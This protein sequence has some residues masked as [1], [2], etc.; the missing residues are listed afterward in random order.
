[1]PVVKSSKVSFSL[2][3]T[4][5]IVISGSANAALDIAQS[6]LFINAAVPPLNMLVMGRD[7]TLYYEAYNDASDLD[8]DGLLDIRF[9]P[10]KIDYYGYFDSAKCYQYAEGNTRFE[11]VGATSNSRFDGSCNGNWSGNFLN[12]V[13]MSRIDALRKVLYGGKRVTDTRTDDGAGVTVLERSAIPQDGHSWGKEYTSLAVDGYDISDYTPLSVPQAGTRHLFANVTIGASP[14]TSGNAPLLRVLRNSRFRIW[15]WVSIEAPVA[16][17]RC[18]HGGSGPTCVYDAGQDTSHPSSSLEFSD[19][20]DRMQGNVLVDGV[21]RT[22]INKTAS[23]AGALADSGTTAGQADNYVSVLKGIIKVPTSGLYKFAV[24]GDDAVEVLI[25]GQ[26]IVG[27]YGGHG[28]GSFADH[29]G[30]ITLTAGNHNIEF[31]HEEV[32]GGDSYSLAW[33]NGAAWDVVPASWFENLRLWAYGRTVPASTRDNPDYVVRVQVCAAELEEDNCQSYTRIDGDNSYLTY[34]PV[35]LLQEFGTATDNT[36]PAR[37]KFG[38]LTGSYR[39]NLKG[40]VLRRNVGDISDELDVETGVFNNTVVGVIETID[41]LGFMGYNGSQHGSNG[42]SGGCGLITGR[43]IDNNQCNMW[44]NPVAEMI[45]ETLRYFAGARSATSAFSE[46]VSTSAYETGLG[47]PLAA[48]DDPYS[49]QGAYSCAAP[50]QTIISDINPSYDTDDLPGTAFGDGVTVSPSRLSS[51]NVAK[52]GQTIWNGEFG[53]GVSRQHFIGQSAAASDGAPTAKSVTSFGNIRGLAPAEPTKMGGYY[54]ASLAYYGLRND[55][56]AATGEQ[57]LSSYVVAL[58]SPLPQFRIPVGDRFITLVPFGKS[59]GSGSTPYGSYYPTNTIVDFY[60]ENIAEDGRSGTFRINFEDVEQG[61]DHD[62]DA[63]VRYEYEVIGDSQLRLRLTSEYAAGSVVQH[64]G[65]VISGSTADG[66]Y[67]EVRD[68]DTSVANDVSVA[69]TLDTPPSRARP[70]DARGADELPLQTTRT[71][72]VNTSSGASTASLLKGPLWYA[73]KWGGFKDRNG[74]GIPDLREEWTGADA[75]ELDP[76]PDNYYLVTNALGLRDQLSSAFN[77]ILIQT[78]SAAA[79]A[80]NSTRLDT[81][82]Q[83]FQAR[84]NSEFWSGELRALSLNANGSIGTTAWEASELIPPEDGRLIATWDH[85]AEV[86]VEFEWS[87]LS[88]TYQAAMGSETVLNYVRGDTGNER[89]NGGTYR[90]RPAGLLG[91]IVNSDPVFVGNQDFGF[92]RLPVGS[93]ERPLLGSNPYRDFKASVSRKAMVYAGAND[94]MLH[95]FCAGSCGSASPGQEILAYVPGA[96]AYAPGQGSTEPARLIDLANP[97]YQH[98]YYVD[99]SARVVD[100]YLGSGDSARWA[101]VLVGSLGAG[102]RS[103]FALDVTNPDEFGAEKVLWEFPRASTAVAD[104]LEVGVGITQPTISRLAAG[105]KWVAIFG[106]GYNSQSGQ[107]AL[108]IVDLNTGDLI[109]RI[110]V[111]A[112]GE[113]GLSAVYPADT[114]GDGITDY[115][116]A[117]DMKGNVWRFDLN[118]TTQTSWT[119]GLSGKPVFTT[120]ANQPITTRIVAGSHPSGGVM[121]Y[122]G[123][124]RYLGDTDRVV[125]DNPPV[126][127][128]YGLWD[129]SAAVNSLNM[130]NKTRLVSLNDLQQ[131]SIIY[132]SSSATTVSGSAASF[133]V[134]VMSNTEFEYGTSSSRKKGW[135]LDLVYPSG[136]AGDG[137]RVTSAATLRAGKIIFATNTPS[138]DACAYGG[139]SWLMEVDALSGKQLDGSVFDVNNDGK[140]DDADFALWGSNRGGVGGR[141]FD[142]LIRN[143]GIISGGEIEYKYTSGSSG[144]I[145][146]TKE[147]AGSAATGRQS[148]RQLQ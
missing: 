127:S 43:A 126:Q 33:W 41:R 72:T 19:L 28:T 78:S 60:V 94:G 128:F 76:D 102:G 134:R 136:A 142:E 69:Y 140:I 70:S 16:G 18:E 125:V 47:L 77:N 112:A 12:Y 59:V 36:S 146:V 55:L 37:M 14:A 84:F 108:F 32:G 29:A 96:L 71:F 105:N 74:N 54:S 5:L 98:R 145:G 80:T 100:A 44:G 114:N 38:L 130:S 56:S 42:N 123:T 104:R 6:P 11:P 135:Y 40:G 20:I 147:D 139:S 1:M 129:Y 10:S 34:K 113:N 13:T 143:P 24:N 117:G 8:G 51:L 103:I 49:R 22:R 85:A 90:D 131:Q 83:I 25:D 81:G 67:L 91:D 137:E 66:V 119:V 61:N 86:P 35:G 68:E 132:E 109:K 124:G 64:M 148:W 7:H 141:G 95:G 30:S 48:W 45:Y 116:Y 121:L 89:R 63:I 9:K 92:S 23:G 97:A 144:N 118:G 111:G 122:F 15:E 27:W 65:Y 58:A 17:E 39:N 88:S 53:P 50:V 79:V 138:G 115:A 52:E 3:L 106:N 99:G 107:A 26:L 82:T 101:T 21:A 2:F 120:Q 75:D 110:P 4:A 46:S 133:P 73:A 87:A 31:R 57:K 93:P 62:M